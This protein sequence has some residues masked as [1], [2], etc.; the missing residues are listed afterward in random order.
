MSKFDLER[1]VFGIEGLT[2]ITPTVFADSRG[3]F[4]ETYNE[5]E[6]ADAG[7]SVKFVQ[8]N[9]SLSKKGV[10]RGLH[11]QREHA[12]GKLICAVA[13]SFFDVAVDLRKESHT[14]GKWFGIILSAENKKQLYIPEGFAQGFLVLEDNT[15]FSAK[16]TDYQYK[17][18]ADGIAWNDPDLKIDWRLDLLGDSEVVQSEADKARKSLAFLIETD[19]LPKTEKR[20]G[21]MKDL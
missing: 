2:I 12:Q 17:E 11:F 4:M 16:V 21:G 9:Q 1:N 3:Y 13:G 7:F 18:F 14:F 20:Y 15:I 10:L 5:R 8:D 19:G 6:L